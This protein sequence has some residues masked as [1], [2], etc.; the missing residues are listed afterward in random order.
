VGESRRLLGHASRAVKIDT[1]RPG[2]AQLARA[3]QLLEHEGGA[4]EGAAAA[5]RVYDKLHAH[6]DPLLGAAGVQAL[7]VRSARL[8]HGPSSPLEVAILAGSTNLRACLQAQDP[9]VAT[10]SAAALFGTF[11]ALVIGFIGERLTIQ[12]L[13]R[14]WPTIDDPAPW[15]TGK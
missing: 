12:M 4:D 1:T 13:R 8:T 11:F 3:R 10:E 6:L 7:L 14:A 5:A 2:P 9:A 15:E